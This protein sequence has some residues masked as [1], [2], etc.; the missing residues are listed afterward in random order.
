MEAEA[1]S[2]TVDR[3]FLELAVDYLSAVLRYKKARHNSIN[4]YR[5]GELHGEAENELRESWKA[6]RAISDKVDKWGRGH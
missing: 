3:E 1:R 6:M 5:T 2:T 4:E